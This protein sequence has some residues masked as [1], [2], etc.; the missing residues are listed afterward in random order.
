MTTYDLDLPNVSVL[1]FY[2]KNEAGEK[3]LVLSAQ[4]IYLEAILTTSQK[5]IHKPRNEN[6]RLWWLKTFTSLLNEQYGCDLSE[7]EAHTVAVAV[8]NLADELKKNMAHMRK[9]LVSMEL[10]RSASPAPNSNVST[11]MLDESMPKENSET[12]SH[13]A[14]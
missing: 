6:I 13:E 10:T 4:A 14:R 2:R 8:A 11:S 12:V 1:N 5:T 3:V 7:T 9:L